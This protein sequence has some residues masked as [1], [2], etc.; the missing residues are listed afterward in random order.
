MDQASLSPIEEAGRG[1]GPKVSDADEMGH[2]TRE[3]RVRQMTHV[4]YVFWAFSSRF[5]IFCNIANISLQ[6]HFKST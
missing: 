2:A 3:T 1:E 5:W 4:F 6:E